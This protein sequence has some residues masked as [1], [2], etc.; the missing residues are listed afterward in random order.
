[1]KKKFERIALPLI[2]LAAAASITSC[3]VDD[4]YANKSDGN[5]D[6]SASISD[7]DVDVPSDISAEVHILIPSGNDNETTMI[8][9]AWDEGFSLQYPNASLKLEYTSVSS[10]ETTVRNMAMSGKLADIVWTNSPEYLYLIKNDIAEP[11][12]GYISSETKANRWNWSDYRKAYFDMGSLNG[13]HYVVPRSADSVVCFYNKKLLQDANIDMS[14]IKDGW[15]WDDFKSVCESWMEHLRSQG[16]ADGNYACDMYLT[17]WGSVG[18]PMLRSYGADVLNEKGEV[19]IDSQGTRDMIKEIR[20]ITDK[21]YIVRAGVTSGSSF[22]FGTTPFCFQS[23]SISHYDTKA[24]IKGNVDLVTLPLIEAN[25]S[26]KVGAGIAGYTIN[27]KSA[28]KKIAWKFLQYLVSREGQEYM[29]EG[30]LNLAPIRSDM[31]DF[32]KEK[33][34]EGY[35]DKNLGAYLKNDEYK[36]TEE[37]LSRADIKYMSRLQLAF[38]DFLMDASQARKTVDAVVTSAV[39]NFKSAMGQ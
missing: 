5:P 31:D 34:G 24:N 26:P 7:V 6:A 25:H 17:G 15:T 36:I 20:D 33:W 18:Y 11:L 4:P 35:T 32:T 23:A 38:Q 28:N 39:S 13:V 2:A 14:K 30:G 1:M 3:N 9:T 12:D 8:K 16:N 29:A 10:Y 19:V 27:K 22:E 37:Y 21:G